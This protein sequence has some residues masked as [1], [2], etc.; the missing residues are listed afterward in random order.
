MNYYRLGEGYCGSLLPLELPAAG[1]EEA[2]AAAGVLPVVT[3]GDPAR[4]RA[5]WKV[6]HPAQLGCPPE[7]PAWLDADR[8]PA[9]APLPPPLPRGWRRGPSWG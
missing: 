4:T 2:L 1:E 9:G 5:S 7:G 3:E 6:T 8:L